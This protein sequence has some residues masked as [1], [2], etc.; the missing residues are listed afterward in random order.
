MARSGIFGSTGEFFFA[1]REPVLT[2]TSLA[3]S[4]TINALT[5]SLIVFKIFKVYSEVKPLYGQTFGPTGGSKL[6]PVIFIVIESGMALFAIQL[7][8][9]VAT[10]VWRDAAQNI[11][12][13]IVTIH[14]MLNVIITS[15][16]DCH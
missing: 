3:M 7:V 11:S 4:L 1:S 8:R 13:W 2:D 10:I 16:H 12:Q 15:V 9:L 6:R 14:E 5:T